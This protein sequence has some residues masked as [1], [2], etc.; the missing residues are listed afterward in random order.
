MGGLILP[1]LVYVVKDEL[2]EDR[3]FRVLWLDPGNI[4][5]WVIDVNSSKGLPELVKVSALI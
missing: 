1:N 2:G 4:I 3:T 5:A